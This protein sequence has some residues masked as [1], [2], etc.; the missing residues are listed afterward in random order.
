MDPDEVA[1]L[2]E[3]QSLKETK[4]PLA[5]I[6]VVVREEEYGAWLCAS[7]LTRRN[8]SALMQDKR[9]GSTTQDKKYVS[10]QGLSSMLDPLKTS[11]GAGLR[12][13]KASSPSILAANY[14]E[15]SVIGTICMEKTGEAAHVPT[16]IKP[17]IVPVLVESTL[18]VDIGTIV[19]TKRG[20]WKRWAQD[21]M[22]IE[23][24]MRHQSACGKCTA[25]L[26]GSEKPLSVACLN[27]SFN[28][29][30]A[31]DLNF[32]FQLQ[33][34]SEMETVVKI[35]QPGPLGIIEHNF[36][37]EEICQANATV[38]KA[39]DNWQRNSKLEQGNESLKDF[40]HK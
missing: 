21:G 11:H 14:V 37:A 27:S 4:E 29:L 16:L 9:P 7:S 15:E 40:I 24:N 6:E 32:H 5:H 20:K 36:S 8:T 23:R 26:F 25:S 1:R 22:K 18:V 31:P 28:S 17:S 13:D 10:E 34:E 3:A 30:V 2:C 33:L 12:H 38:R 35:L 39:V 19:P